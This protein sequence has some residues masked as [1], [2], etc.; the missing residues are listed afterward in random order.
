MDLKL[1]ERD[2]R[3]QTRGMHSSISAIRNQVEC[4][5]GHHPSHQ[6]HELRFYV[7]FARIY[8]QVRILQRDLSDA[9]P[10]RYRASAKHLAWTPRAHM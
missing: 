4:L 3:N 5:V 10:N 9:A 8:A 1:K 6:E 7:L 2:R